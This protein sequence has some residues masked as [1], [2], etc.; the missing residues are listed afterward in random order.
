MYYRV[1]SNEHI[2][3]EL[4]LLMKEFQEFLATYKN[5]FER[6]VHPDEMND[7]NAMIEEVEEKVNP[8]WHTFLISLIP[9]RVC[10]LSRIQFPL[11]L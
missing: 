7:Y 2:I 10:H 3:E 5:S 11:N 8:G 9:P 4:P 1:F 6:L